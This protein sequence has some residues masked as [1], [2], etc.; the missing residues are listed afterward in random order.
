[1]LPLKSLLATTA[2]LVGA[3]AGAALPDVEIKTAGDRRVELKVNDGGRT[4]EA[5]FDIPPVETIEVRNE[6]YDKLRLW[7]PRAGGWQQEALRKTKS[8]ECNT[9]FVYTPGTLKVTSGRKADARVYERGKD[10]EVNEERGTFGRLEGG[11]IAEDTK[12]Y[13]SYKYVPQ[14]MDSVFLKDGKLELVVG[15][16]H[17]TNPKPPAGPDGGVRVANILTRGSRPALAP[18]DLYPIRETEFPGPTSSDIAEKLLPG[19]MKKLRSGEPL[20][21]LAWGDSVT[22]GGFV[23]QQFKWQEQFVSRLK[24]RFP[25]ANIELLN[26]GW[27]GR[28]TNTFLNQSKGT[29]FDYESKLLN[30]KA[31]LVVS[32]FVN[33][34]G[35]G[36]ENFESNYNRILKDFRA[37]GFEW[38]ILTPHYIGGMKEQTEDSRNYVTMVR[39]FAAENNIPVAEGSLRY[40]R[41]HL[42]GLS[43][44]T[45]MANGF[46]HP[47]ERGM[48]L[49][50]DALMALFPEK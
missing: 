19:T 39:Q 40:G 26:L 27:G 16:P 10:Y 4:A 41:L 7:N 30:S 49:F 8:Q 35:L 45:L 13:A 14:R 11:A 3:A 47:D 44:P 28:N 36:R 17:V 1:M 32:E 15:T 6:R 31:D 48:K 23:P 42:Q 12:V 24:E 25:K 21:I 18:T 9:P 2:L 22:G 20:R 33:D 43:F 37:A 38:I 50:A 34:G 46:N 5:T 29:P